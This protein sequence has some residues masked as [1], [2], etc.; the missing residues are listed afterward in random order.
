MIFN[1]Y[2]WRPGYRSN[3]SAKVVG[4][5]LAELA[6]ANDDAITPAL[7]VEDARPDD[8]PLHRGFEWDDS[9]AG[10][11]WRED[12]ARRMIRNCY[13]VMK[14]A[15]TG[16]EETCLG[17]VSVKL[18]DG[19]NGYITTMRAVFDD[20]L[21]GQVE[22][23][24]MRAFQALRQRYDHIRSLAGVFREIDKV[25]AKAKGKR[26]AKRRDGGARPVAAR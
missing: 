2:A 11:K 6:Q 13:V 15:D 10:E 8:A 3:V 20:D 5:R 14:D 19:T 23:E 17:N 21:R 18:A 24:A 4:Q 7:V 25:V 12:E 1:R 9:V 16:L 26:K 22:A